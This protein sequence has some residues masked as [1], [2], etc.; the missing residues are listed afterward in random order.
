[1]MVWVILCLI[2]VT[3]IVLVF[4]EVIFVPGT[5]LVGI[6][7]LLCIIGGVW[8][9]F[10][11]FG[12]SVGW[13]I[14]LITFFALIIAII[15]GFK[16]DSWNRFALN[17]SISS[18]VND[19][20]PITVNIGDVGIT[21]SALRPIGNA[22]FGNEKMEVSTLGELVDSGSNIAVTQIEGRVIYVK[23]INI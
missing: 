8:Y 20:I 14:S 4:V 9:G 6:L 7:G 5:T 22:E 10:S 19:H 1:M 2:I 23:Q 16:S 21:V 3:G 11:N 13:T 18:R 15:I 17:N 12:E